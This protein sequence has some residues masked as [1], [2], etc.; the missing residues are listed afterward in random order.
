MAQ[1]AFPDV[2]LTPRLRA[3]RMRPAHLP[4]IT[5]MHANADVMATMG[6][7]RD[8][9]ASRIYVEQNL[10]HWADYGYG[11]YVLEDPQTGKLAGR[12]GLKYTVS[13][14]RGA[15]EL[16][17]AFQPDCWGRGYAGEISASLIGMG[18]TLLPVDVLAGVAVR[19]NVASRRVMEKTGLRYVGETEGDNPKVRYEI[20][21]EQW[22]SLQMQLDPKPKPKSDPTP[23]STPDA[24]P[25]PVAPERPA[26]EECCNSGCIP[27]VYDT[28]DEAMD[29]YR[30]ALKAWRARHP[31]SR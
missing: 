14:E 24:D 1:A 25:E 8:A 2:F 26:P 11:M 15:V 20:R 4:F 17:Y 3:Q 30:Q 16:A 28:Y 13:G 29:Q 18:F 23:G 31:E 22:R 19:S 27:C 9:A 21:R 12:A 7:T 10:T 6:G 5:E